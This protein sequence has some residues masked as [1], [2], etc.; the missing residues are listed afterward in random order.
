[1]RALGALAGILLIIGPCALAQSPLAPTQE[2]ALKAGDAFV[3]CPEMVVIPA[4]EFLMGSPETEK[5]RD[6]SE[7]PPHRVTLPCGD[8]FAFTGAG[9]QLRAECV[10]AFRHARQRIRMGRGLLER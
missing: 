3:E 4:G 9:R 2:R 7:G 1:M 5:D 8:G 10:R 6:D